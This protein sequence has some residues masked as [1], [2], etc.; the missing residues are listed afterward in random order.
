MMK[1]YRKSKAMGATIRTLK[2]VDEAHIESY[3]IS[4]STYEDSYVDGFLFG[5]IAQIAIQVGR[6]SSAEDIMEFRFKALAGAF[7]SQSAAGILDRA[8][9][10]AATKDPDFLTGV[11]TAADTFQLTN[12]VFNEVPPRATA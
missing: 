7:G 6:I 4:L 5:A 3:G 9:R 2:T 12:G 8:G 10:C 11:N 1:L